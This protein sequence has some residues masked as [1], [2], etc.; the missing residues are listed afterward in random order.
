MNIK[1]LQDSVSVFNSTNWHDTSVREGAL[2]LYSM[3]A[4]LFHFYIGCFVPKKWY[5]IRKFLG[6]NLKQ[7]MVDEEG[8]RKEDYVT[9]LKRK[10]LCQRKKQ[11]SARAVPRAVKKPLH[12]MRE[13]Q[14]P[15]VCNQI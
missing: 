9:L 10:E 13:R 5:L 1:N 3:V 6:A 8:S 14:R 11:R 7:G 2:P 4:V 15:P 12:L